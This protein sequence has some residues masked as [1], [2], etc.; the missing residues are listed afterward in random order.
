MVPG[1]NPITKS[2]TKLFDEQSKSQTQ[3]HPSVS[4]FEM[5]VPIRLKNATNDTIVVLDNT[6]SGQTFTVPL[7]FQI[8]SLILDPDNWIICNQNIITGIKDDVKSTSSIKEGR[9][10]TNKL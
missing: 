8:D 5:P 3:S 9:T 7:N 1:N 6:F 10:T 4:F 2:P